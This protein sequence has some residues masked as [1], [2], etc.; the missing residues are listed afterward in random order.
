MEKVK[1][2]EETVS[3]GNPKIDNFLL[4]LVRGATVSNDRISLILN[5]KGLIVSGLLISGKSY[6]EKNGDEIAQAKA[7]Y[8]SEEAENIKKYFYDIAQEQL[9]TIELNFIHLEN[10][11]I[12]SGSQSFKVGLWRGKLEEVDGY[13]IG[14]LGK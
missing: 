6:F 1:N 12:W 13:S 14:S 9:E 7:V 5:V 10:T 8:S 2:S 3:Q 11:T 4:N